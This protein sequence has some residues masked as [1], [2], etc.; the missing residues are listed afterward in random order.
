M[1]IKF[2]YGERFVSYMHYRLYLDFELGM[3]NL[4]FYAINMDTVSLFADLSFL[5]LAIMNLY[6]IDV[7]FLFELMN[8]IYF[9][10]K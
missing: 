3:C 8:I 4:P 1:I 6:Y 2:M 5:F 9:I 7:L 10:K